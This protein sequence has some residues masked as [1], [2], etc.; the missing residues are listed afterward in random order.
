MEWSTS[1]ERDMVTEL[2]KID[3][4]LK[5]KNLYL[6]LRIQFGLSCDCVIYNNNFIEYINMF[7]YKKKEEKV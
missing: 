6:D 1:R 7:L 5:I 2:T 4:R 3:Y